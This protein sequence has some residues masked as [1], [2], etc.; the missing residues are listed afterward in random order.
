MTRKSAYQ[1]QCRWTGDRLVQ[2]RRIIECED[3]C[4]DLDATDTLALVAFANAIDD[5]IITDRML[6]DSLPHACGG[7]PRSME[8]FEDTIM[9]GG[10]LSRWA[11]NVARNLPVRIID[12]ADNIPQ[13]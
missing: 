9:G 5:G 7:N 6:E 13:E 4:G 3:E 8:D 12:D 10:T 2:A 11:H 1:R